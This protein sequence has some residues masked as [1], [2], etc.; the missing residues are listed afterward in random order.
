ML[1][2]WPIVG[3]NRP[4][5]QDCPSRSDHLKPNQ[6]AHT[7]RGIAISVRSCQGIRFRGCCVGRLLRFHDQVEEPLRPKT[8]TS[9]SARSLLKPVQIQSEQNDPRPRDSERT[10]AK[11]FH[12]GKNRSSRSVPFSRRERPFSAHLKLEDGK[13]GFEFPE[14]PAS[15]NY[16]KRPNMS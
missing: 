13:V 15:A 4:R 1:I 5:E 14:K 3:C 10:G 16:S 7:G 2:V 8:V 12:Y 9:V 11:T 6:P